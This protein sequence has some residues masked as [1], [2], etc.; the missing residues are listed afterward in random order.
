MGS[1]MAEITKGPAPGELVV[2][3]GERIQRMYAA[4]AGDTVWVFHDGVVYEIADPS[5]GR[6]RVR[7]SAGGESLTAPM[8]AT[9]VDVKVKAGDAVKRGDI[10][11]VL[12]AMKMELPVRA[13]GDGTVSAVH[14]RPGELVQ[15]DTVL[16]EITSGEPRGDAEPGRGT[17]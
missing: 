6:A 13:L 16:L 2:R 8:P 11:I 4:T 14:C 17:A 10:V 1:L 9:V 3:D 7:A 12:E 5:P 15:P